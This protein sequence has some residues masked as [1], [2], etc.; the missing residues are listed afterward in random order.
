MSK[1]IIAT[2]KQSMKDLKYGDPIPN[3]NR[4]TLVQVKYDGWFSHITVK[5][6]FATV[7]TSGGE[8]RKRF[9]IDIP[10]CIVLAEWM[11]GTNSSQTHQLKDKFIIHDILSYNGHDV[12][13]NMYINRI[14]LGVGLVTNLHEYPNFP[15]V[16]IQSYSPEQFD[17]VWE[18]DI[19]GHGNEGVVFKHGY[20]EF[21]KDKM[22]RMKR[23]FTNDYVVIG[24]K[25]GTGRL[26]GTL[27]A[28]IGGL[29]YNGE[30]IRVISVGG[31]FNDTQRDVIW[32]SQES[33]KGMVFEATGKALF[34]SGALRHPAFQRFR[35]DKYPQECKLS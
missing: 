28:L 31:G 20:A 19:L 21:N 33:F 3:N 2:V 18:R 8:V 1:E 29:Y 9:D 22:Y 14:S 12:R 5:D 23:E 32:R 26:K 35:M 10:D 16:L 11:Y 24:F 30:L 4:D 7:I 6:G 34:S 25:E 15:L 17:E 27:G 13:D